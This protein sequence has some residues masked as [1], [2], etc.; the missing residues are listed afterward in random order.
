[1]SISKEAH[2]ALQLMLQTELRMEDPDE[3]AV[4]DELEAAGLVEFFVGPGGD[5]LRLT[6][7]GVAA[8]KGAT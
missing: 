5:C 7:K 6:P 2:E 8:K 3:R 4:E 1:M